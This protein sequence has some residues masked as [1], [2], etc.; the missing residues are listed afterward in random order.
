[1]IRSF[2]A[3]A[4]VALLC[5]AASADGL[6]YQ[7]PKD[8]SWSQYDTKVQYKRGDRTIDTSG[9]LRIASVGKVTEDDKACRWIEITLE[10][11]LGETSRT[12]V[13]KL[14]TPESELKAGGN[15]LKKRLRGWVRMGD[16]AEVHEL[17]DDRLGPLNIWLA[18]P[19]KEQKTLEPEEVDSVLGSKK[20]A[21]VTGVT[22]FTENGNENRAVIQVRRHNDAPFGAVTSTTTV[23][24]RRD[25]EI[26]QTGELSFRL[27]GIGTDAETR[28]PDHK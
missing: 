1:M 10:M 21:G 27:T 22:E 11:K 26:F 3:L 24:I 14:L 2:S 13:A 18:P 7:L 15:P 9:K 25:N 8:G 17:T 4:V 16:N 12:I 28:L 5:S 23:E 6:I 20:C 19:L